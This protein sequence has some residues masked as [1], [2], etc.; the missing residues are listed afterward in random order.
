MISLP[1]TEAVTTELEFA[2]PGIRHRIGLI[3]LATAETTERDFHALLPEGAL[4]HTTRVLNANPVTLENLRAHRD[5][6]ATAAG[7]LVPGVPLDVVCYDCTAGTVASG[8]EAIAAEV[9]KALPGVPVV[10]PVTAGLAAFEALGVKNISLLTPYEEEVNAAVGS[11]LSD[12]GLNVLNISSF[13]I[14]SDIDMA[15]VTPE[16]IRRAAVAACAPEADGLFISCTALRAVE[17]IDEIEEE[18]GK[19]VVSSVQAQFWQCLRIAGFEEPLE[20]HGT[21]LRAH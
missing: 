15:R 9:H 17:V 7:Q 6:I 2:D 11:Y 12:H 5:L 13:L 10:T 1:K 14:E 19:P 16:S 8:Y 3:E 21:L 4:F 20:G 18:I